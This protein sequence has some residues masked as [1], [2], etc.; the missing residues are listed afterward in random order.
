MDKK[1]MIGFGMVAVGI[2][3]MVICMLVLAGGASLVAKPIATKTAS[4][5]NSN[6][7]PLEFEDEQTKK[8][9]NPSNASTSDSISIPGI[10]KWTISSGKTTVETDFYNPE[11]NDCYFVLTV[12]L[13]AGNEQIYQSKYL[14][15]GQHLY[16]IE[17]TKG[18]EAGEYEAVLRYDT[19]AI[20]DNS[21]LNGASVPFTLVVK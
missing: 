4:M 6:N 5:Q 1:K 18:L 11:K 16:E 12:T 14:K 2:A 15:P 21:P 3:A 13:T 7:G 9:S 8:I 10:K 20:E 19:Y 17:L